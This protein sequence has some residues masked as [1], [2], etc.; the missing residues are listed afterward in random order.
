MK[1]S[2]AVTWCNG[3]RPQATG[4]IE[5]AADAIELDGSADGRPV[6]EE[7]PYAD[8]A[9]VSIGRGSRDRIGGR[10]A[11]V[12]ARTGHSPIRVA[13]VAEA[14]IVSELAERLASHHV[15]RRD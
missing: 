8:V 9:S 6:H 10:Q 13:G 5:L 7:I 1:S 2:Y 15:E 11:L 4:R 14:W 3:A 12:L